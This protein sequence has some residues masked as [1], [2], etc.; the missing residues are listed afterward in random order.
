MS[1]FAK[2]KATT[3]QMTTPSAHPQNHSS[4]SVRSIISELLSVAL[5]LM[6][7]AGTFS[8]VLFADRTLLL[9]YDGTSMSASMAGG[10]F[11]WVATCLPVGI[12]SMTGAIISQYVG[13][14]E[15]HKIGRF[16]WQSIFLGI[17]S[18]PFFSL[19]AVA[20]PELFRFAEQ[21]ESLIPAEVTYMRLLLVGA[22]GAVLENALSGFFS[23]TE[24]TRVIMWVSLASGIINLVLDWLLIFGPGPFPELGI[25]G[26]A[27]G[28]SI[29]FWFK[30]AC[31]ASLIFYY[32][33]DGRYQVRKQFG[34]DWPLIEKLLYFGFP[35]G[36]MFLTEASGFTAMVLR[37]GRLGDVPL[38]ATTMAINFNM[39]AFIPLVG[40]SI[41]ASVLVGRHLI[42]T[43]P[44]R[45]IKSVV[46][47]LAIGWAY[48][49]VWCAAYLL[50]PD[51]MMNLYELNT[52]SEESAQAIAIARGLL[53]FVAIYVVVDATQL[54]LAGALRGAGDT[55]FVLG[56]G[57]VTSV[58]SF[59]V[60][61]SFEPALTFAQE[62]S[63]ASLHWWWW[64]ITM[65]VWLL[66]IFM[67][68]RFIQGRW[69][70]MRMV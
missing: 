4:D 42:E 40:V 63:N 43:G 18:I 11:F 68:G 24:R 10:N 7:S 56:T 21:P 35:S 22:V 69:K 1:S 55:W 2:R 27:I 49:A 28:S 61:L 57:M 64:M 50:L 37:I 16:L 9:W 60:G 17:F 29:A 13:A 8:L 39:V 36:L 26:A 14:G 62:T 46:A 65:W 38:R 32:D 58:F 12:A 59:A 47:A 15:E 31:F 5:P 45:A 66:A 54:I 41:A 19:V 3:T 30:A 44:S 23:G 48:S 34:F 6:V 25:A 67:A 20:A 51:T 52:P 53:T 33:R 70:K